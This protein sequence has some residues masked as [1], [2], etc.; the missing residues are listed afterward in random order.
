MV[1]SGVERFRLLGSG[2]RRLRESGGDLLDSEAPDFAIKALGV[3]GLGL[4][5]RICQVHWYCTSN[6]KP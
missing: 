6:P 5:L 2:P 3:Q 4:R 1:A